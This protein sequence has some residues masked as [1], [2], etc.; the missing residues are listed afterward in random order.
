MQ[1][2]LAQTN[3]ILEKTIEQEKLTSAEV[4]LLR[5]E[6]GLLTEAQKKQLENEKKKAEMLVAAVIEASNSDESVAERRLEVELR[7]R[8]EHLT[9]YVC[10]CVCVCVVKEKEK[11]RSRSDAKNDIYIYIY[12]YTHTHIHTYSHTH[13]MY[14]HT[15]I[16]HIYIY[17]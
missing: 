16:H 11:E 6:L 5:Y 9:R 14:I 7:D 4:L 1:I 3:E 10:M 17:I 15:Y 13:H 12:I 2:K 8:V